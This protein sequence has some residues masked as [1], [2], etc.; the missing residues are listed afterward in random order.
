[1]LQNGPFATSAGKGPSW[2]HTLCSCLCSSPSRTPLLFSV[3]RR[4]KMAIVQQVIDF[5]FFFFFSFCLQFLNNINSFSQE[6]PVLIEIFI[7]AA[8][9]YL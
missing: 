3:N 5:F 6:N 9:G 8:V 4:K 2:S 7:S 1:M